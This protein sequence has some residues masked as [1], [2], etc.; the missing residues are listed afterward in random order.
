MH[1]KNST[2]KLNYNYHLKAETAVLHMDEIPIICYKMSKI[3]K[4]V[5]SRILN[6]QKNLLFSEEILLYRVQIQK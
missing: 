5:L 6:T 4:S 1:P 2:T 3:I